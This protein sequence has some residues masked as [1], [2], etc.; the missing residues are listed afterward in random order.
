M[1]KG[2]TRREFIKIIGIS[3]PIFL[4]P[5]WVQR[6]LAGEWERGTKNYWVRGYFEQKTV[7]D[8]DLE[9]GI[10]K[11]KVDKKWQEFRLC[12]LPEGFLGWNFSSRI[13][14]LQGIKQGKCHPLQVHTPG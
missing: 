1:D 14:S 6:L 7:K 8:I 5:G 3:I 10:I 11:A 9:K 12:P 4:I 13:K 2:L